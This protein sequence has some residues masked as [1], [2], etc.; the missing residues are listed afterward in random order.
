EQAA[1]DAIH[2]ENAVI[3]H[4]NIVALDE[5]DL[6]A[7]QSDLSDLA[8]A[9]NMITGRDVGQFKARLAIVHDDL[10]TF[11]TEQGTEIRTKTALEFKVKKV[12]QSSLRQE[13]YL[14]VYS[15]FVG[16]AEVPDENY[17]P[18]ETLQIGAE[19]STGAGLVKWKVTGG[20]A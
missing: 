5:F 13:E 9:L 14:P 7:T 12:K 20:T 16:Y 2:H 3:A 1:P 6:R 11:L 15:I 17:F 10:F 19:A 8:N 4:Q 18:N